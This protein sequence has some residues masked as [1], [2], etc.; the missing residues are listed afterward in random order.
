MFKSGLKLYVYPMID[1][2]T[3]QLLTAANIL[4]SRRTCVRSFAT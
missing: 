4:R 1:E 2:Q 3:G